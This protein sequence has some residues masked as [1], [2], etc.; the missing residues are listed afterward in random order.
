[1]LLVFV[2]LCL[3]VVSQA[4]LNKYCATKDFT[5]GYQ[6]WC[7]SGQQIHGLWPN[8]DCACASDEPFDLES[9]DS[10]T[11]TY[12]ND[13]WNACGQSNHDLW[14]HEW[15][16]HGRCSGLSQAEYFSASVKTFL[17]QKKG[18]SGT[19][20]TKLTNKEIQALMA[21]PYQSEGEKTEGL[22]RQEIYLKSL[23]IMIIFGALAAVSLLGNAC[24]KPTDEEL[25]GKAKRS[26]AS[27]DGMKRLSNQEIEFVTPL[28]SRQQLEEDN[29]KNNSNKNNDNIIKE[30]VS[31]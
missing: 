27:K 29:G 11:K 23:E 5:F 19:C 22:S 4:D 21:Q 26:L 28:I 1:M 18:C 7:K 12:M 8:P 6:D 31:V 14:S 24:C 17:F 2:F 13:Y 9:I 3:A 25:I 16:K 30:S 15:M 20:K 10:E